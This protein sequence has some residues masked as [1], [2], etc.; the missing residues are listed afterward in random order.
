MDRIVHGLQRFGHDWA[1]FTLFRIL[2]S[3][4]GIPSP[5]LA[6]LAAMLCK[7]HLTSH[8]RM[9][10]SEWETTQSGLSRSLRS[11]LYSSSVCSL[12]LSL[13]F[14]T[15]IRSLPFVSF[16]V[17][18]FGWN[19]PLIFPIFLR[20]SLVLP[21]LLFSSI[22]LH[23]SLKK[24]FL[25][26]L[27][28]FRNSAFSWTYLSLYSLLFTSLLSSAVCKTSSDNHF[29]HL[30]F[31]FFGMVLLDVSCTISWTS[32]HSTLGTLFTKSNTLNLFITSTVYS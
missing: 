6:L 32:V 30:H 8:S 28:V 15:S 27:A 31:I 16:I 24:A 26:L 25:S 19:I 13:I 21:F 23:C 4:A 29:S 17:T 7:A 12:H 11:F 20:R 14:S 18:V 5:P 3:S 10:G 1:T 2:N 22:S 9:S